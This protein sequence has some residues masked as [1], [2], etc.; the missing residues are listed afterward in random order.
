MAV[1]SLGLEVVNA[2]ARYQRSL[3]KAEI[4]M[5]GE[6]D[7]K[8]VKLYEMRLKSALKRSQSMLDDALACAQHWSVDLNNSA[9]SARIALEALSASAAAR[10]LAYHQMALQAE[11]TLLGVAAAN[12][13][14][15]A[16]VLADYLE[17][18]GQD[19][20]AARAAFSE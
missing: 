6:V 2:T 15:P 9:R 16:G 7:H 11:G 1:K 4:S 8:K 20:P 14:V 5:D 17:E 12:S 3:D 13:E 10:A 18:Q 19:Q